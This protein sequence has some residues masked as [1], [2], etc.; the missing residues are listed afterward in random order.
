MVIK[1]NNRFKLIFERYLK[2]SATT[3]YS[4]SNPYWQSGSYT[5]SA[6]KYDGI[7]VKDRITCYFYE[8]SS[9]D[10]GS[11]PFYD[12]KKLI[13]FFDENNIEYTAQDLATIRSSGFIYAVCEPGNSKLMIGTNYYTVRTQLESLRKERGINS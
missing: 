6:N 9:L 5:S 10:K 2:K 12:I 1:K 7:D 13:K 8:W 4:S 11:K 3:S